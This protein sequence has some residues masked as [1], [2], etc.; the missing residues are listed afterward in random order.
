MTLMKRERVVKK[1][2]FCCFV[3]GTYKLLGVSLAATAEE[4]ANSAKHSTLDLEGGG[5]LAHVVVIDKAASEVEKMS[6]GRHGLEA[7]KRV[8]DAQRLVP[9]QLV[10]GRLRLLR[11]RERL[12]RDAVAGRLQHL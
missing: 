3:L 11:L 4:G 7:R 5:L 12:Q 9:L 2:Q 10:E 1:R 8:H 6:R